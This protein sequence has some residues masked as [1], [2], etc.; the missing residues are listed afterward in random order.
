MDS[1]ILAFMREYG[2]LTLV[3]ND[4]DFERVNG[5]QVFAPTDV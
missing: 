5:I 4:L 2:I 3:S 1:M